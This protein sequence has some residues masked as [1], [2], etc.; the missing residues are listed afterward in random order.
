MGISFTEKASKSQYLVQKL[1]KI[2]NQFNVNFFIADK[3]TGFTKKVF[4]DT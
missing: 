4:E 3:V 1:L 2:I